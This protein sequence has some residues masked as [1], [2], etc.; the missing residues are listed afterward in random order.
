MKWPVHKMTCLWNGYW[1]KW[2]VDDTSSWWNDQLIKCQLELN[3]NLLKCIK[4]YDHK[5]FCDNCP[6]HYTA[7]IK[8]VASNKSSLLL[9][10]ILQNTQTLQLN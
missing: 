6:L 10:S 2:P 9:K 3:F 5:K 8:Q 4:S 1:I 7:I